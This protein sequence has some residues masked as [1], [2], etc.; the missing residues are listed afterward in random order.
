MKGTGKSTEGEGVICA[1]FHWS[2]GSIAIE[3]AQHRIRLGVRK[4]K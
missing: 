1:A 2:P 4:G 3:S